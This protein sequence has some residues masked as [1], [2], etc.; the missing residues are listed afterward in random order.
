MPSKT[1]RGRPT[2]RQGLD[3]DVYQVVRKIVD[4]ASETNQ[5]VTVDSVYDTIKH[6][7]SS[8]NRKPK[9]LL[10]D[11]IERV[12]AVVEEEASDE[13]ELGP[14]EGEFKGAD[15]AEKTPVPDMSNIM[16]KSIVGSWAPATPSVTT[17]EASKKRDGQRQANGEPPR[18]RRKPPI[19]QADRSPPSHIS[20]EDVGGVD[21]VKEQ[22]KDLLVL[23]LLCPEEYQ[24][25][26]IPIPRGILLHG[27]PGCG[28]TDI[29]RAFAAK[30]GMPFVEI[31]G[32]SIVSGMSGESEKQVREHFEEARRLAP[33]LIFIDEIDVIAPKRDSAQSQMEKRIV[34]Q[35]L[36]SMDTL[37]MEKNDGKPV[38]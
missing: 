27:P 23:P 21:N 8:L 18:K 26:N 11:S 29:S 3:K 22:L 16:N 36:L 38:I 13:E 28:K 9:K 14:M 32:P 37:A 1:G 20:L 33:C 12:L 30:L 34:A 10:E 19:E 7:T 25:R 35:L 2:L 17:D 4:D 31:A 6:S 5:R 15:F 24:L